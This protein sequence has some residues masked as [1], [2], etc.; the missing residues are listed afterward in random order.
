MQTDIRGLEISTESADA[1]KHLDGAVADFLDY[2][3]TAGA[4]VKAAL[5]AD[6]GADI[7]AMLAEEL[8]T[9]AAR[10]VARAM[11]DR[12]RADIR[13]VP[14]AALE[15]ATVRGVEDPAALARAFGV[16]LGRMF[17]RLATLPETPTRPA[18]GLVVCD[19][20]GEITY[21]KSVDGFVMARH[22]GACPLWPLFAVL[23]RP[24]QP[25]RESIRTQGRDGR[26]FT[27]FSIAEPAQTPGFEGPV[28]F[29]ASMLI[30]PRAHDAGP[31]PDR[32]VGMTCRRCAAPD[33]PARREPS[34]LTDRAF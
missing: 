17:R 25:L 3:Q 12:Y 8:E 15:A 20:S 14:M 5:E 31:Q 16:G 22:G 13:A 23:G 28:L 26:A 4:Q 34:L 10:D 2:G 19:A 9:A 7:E 29:E 21:R 1:A 33:C 27:T 24:A 32:A 18:F 11:L 30:M 6:P